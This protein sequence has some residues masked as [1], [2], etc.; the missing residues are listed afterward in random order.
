MSTYFYEKDES[1]KNESTS[2][3]FSALLNIK[4][5]YKQKYEEYEIEK[6]AYEVLEKGICK[7]EGEKITWVRKEID[8][9]I[10]D[11]KIKEND[12]KKLEDLEVENKD[13]L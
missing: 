10:N 2:N 4:E 3:R 5:N 6:S 1:K 7:N 9:K 8:K 12:K 11:N 13:W